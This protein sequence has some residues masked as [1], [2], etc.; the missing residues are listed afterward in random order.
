MALQ[1]DGHQCVFLRL[2]VR[3]QSLDRVQ[4]L[5]EISGGPGP[6]QALHPPAETLPPIYGLPPRDGEQPGPERRLPAKA[7]KLLEGGHER[8]LRHVVRLSGG[9][10]GGERGP[11]N[12]PA[13]AID[14]LAERVQVPG[15]C[16][17]NQLQVRR[18]GGIGRVHTICRGVEQ[19]A[20]WEK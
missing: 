20:G 7:A 8:I 14:E 6:R 12:S 13:V 1:V 19:H 18:I 9:T 11:E 5:A 3:G 2:V 15:L 4:L 17:A 10:D 16:P